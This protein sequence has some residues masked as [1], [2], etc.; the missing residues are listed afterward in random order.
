MARVFSQI[1]RKGFKEKGAFEQ[2][3]RE[4]S[5]R[6]L[7]EAS[8]AEGSAQPPQ[9]LLD[10]LESGGVFLIPS[11]LTPD[12]LS[13]VQGSPGHWEEPGVPARVLPP[14]P[15]ELSTVVHRL[16]TTFQEALDLYRLVS[17]APGPG[18]RAGWLPG[19]AGAGWPLTRFV[20]LADG[21]QRPGEH[22]AAVAGTD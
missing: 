4:V 8:Q 6:G 21:L 3:R 10:Q 17:P 15:R 14:A 13:L 19:T 12:A 22:G 20:P 2:S 16:Q 11:P 9:P 1:M 5:L 18:E 7:R